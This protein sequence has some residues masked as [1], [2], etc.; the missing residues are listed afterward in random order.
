MGYANNVTKER[1]LDE[2]IP[3]PELGGSFISAGALRS[4]GVKVTYRRD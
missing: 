4:Y 1:Y 3:S 2:V